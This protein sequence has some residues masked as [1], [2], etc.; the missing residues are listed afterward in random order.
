MKIESITLRIISSPL[1]IPFT[2]HLE[3]VSNREAIII[4]ARDKEGRS[5]FG[6]ADPF[7]SPWYTEE[8]ILTCWHVLRDF[9]IP[10][11]LKRTILNPDGLDSLWSGI[12]RNNMAKSGLSQALWDLHAK[13]KNV[14]LGQLFGAARKKVA[15]G[16][17]IATDHIE[18]GIE[19]IERFSEAGYK[20]YKI[21][22]SRISDLKLLSAIRSRF[23]DLS[24]MADANSSYTLQ[25]LDHLQ[26]LDDFNLQM[27]EQ[28]LAF[29]DL[30]E[31]A[32]L[33]SKLKTP[34]CLDE[35]ICTF[36]DARE[37][38]AL[39][40][41]KVVNIKMA[42]VGGWAQALRIH[43]LCFREKIPVWCGG[44]IEFGV[45]KAH[46]IA[47]AALK[48]F[49]LPGDLSA[50]SRYWPNDII[51]PEIEVREG[52]IT[53]PSGPGIGFEI[54]RK[55]LETLTVEHLMIK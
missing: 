33:Q 10:L 1:K 18:K 16:A 41:C 48:G 32:L 39:G 25:D 27:I 3:K 52:F 26:H 30:I 51:D 42:R 23:P 49:T 44:M 22:I 21:K 17:V 11:V 38:L 31:H 43:N 24:L 28:P 40:S 37:A 13:E 15:A 47:L 2:T 50:S 46:N 29:D 12:R 20:R 19:Q 54:N 7:S 14:Y 53:V 9:L 36:N 8:T 34:I 35:S 55:Q 6:E 5:G 4:E 45:A